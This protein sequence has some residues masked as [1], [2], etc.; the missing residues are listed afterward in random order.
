[1]G[2][3]SVVIN[4]YN[5]EKYLREVLSSA[6]AFDEIVVCDMESTD[7]TVAIANEF[8]CKVVVYP[9]GDV[10]ICEPAR[11]T[12]IQ[13][14][15]NPWV[16]I[17]D[18]DELVPQALRDFLYSHI[19]GNPGAAA[20]DIC[21]QNRFMGRPATEG[22][23]R[24][25]RFFRKDRVYWPPTIH[26]RPIIDGKVE[27]M[28]SDKKNLYLIHLDNPTI[29]QR[30]RKLDN[31]STQEVEKRIN[32]SFSCGSLLLRPVWA[33]IR[34]LIFRRGFRDGRRGVIRAQLNAFY[35]LLVMAKVIEKQIEHDEYEP[36]FPEACS[37]RILHIGRNR[38]WIDIFDG[39]KVAVKQFSQGAFRALLNLFRN[40]KATLSKRN[41]EELIRRGFST[42]EPISVIIRRRRIG[43]VKK[44][45]YI[46]RFDGESVSLAEAIKA[47]GDVAIKAFAEFVSKLHQAGILHKDLN[48]TNV[49]VCDNR[50]ILSFSLIDLNR[51]SFFPQGIPVGI[52]ESFDNITRFCCFDET[53]YKF[54]DYYFEARGLDCE[55]RQD[56][57]K[58]KGHHDAAFDRKKKLKII[59][60]I[61]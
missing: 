22:C 14:A 23:D 49:R 3:I 56:A 37:E 53:F 9:K 52:K 24:Q 5:A 1:M 12:A 42:P 21:R 46:S 27:K 6:L 30:V 36:Q 29:A 31:Y 38:V 60:R 43:T 51:M 26:S 50:G 35:Q 17:V 54:I 13:S 55:L 48:N 20:L 28:P 57:F 58:A 25:L 34:T 40:D 7:R 45:Y 2:K 18:A 61:R 11:N 41:A 15:S 33:F 16:L 10:S 59:L 4:T 19:K 47:Y 39:R 8:G 32:R 44:A